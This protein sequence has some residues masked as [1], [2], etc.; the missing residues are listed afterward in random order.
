MENSS[1]KE[2]KLWCVKLHVWTSSLAIEF[3]FGLFCKI[4][5]AV[6]WNLWKCQTLSESLSLKSSSLDRE[7]RSY[8]DSI[9]NVS[10]HSLGWKNEETWIILEIMACSCSNLVKGVI[11]D[12]NS[13]NN[14]C[15]V[16]LISK[17]PNYLKTGVWNSLW[18][19]SDV[20][21]SSNVWKFAL[22]TFLERSMFV[23]NLV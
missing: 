9:T 22:W 5:L 20:I 2:Q 12:S 15:D 16:I 21:F 8:V 13:S 10:H 18:R 4:N 23:Q 11:L 17:W 3:R 1:K 7:S 14:L 19:H 6:V